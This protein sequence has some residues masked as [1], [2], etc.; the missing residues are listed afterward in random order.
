MRVALVHY[1]L[2]TMRG[3]EKMLEALCRMYPQADIFTHVYDPEA[4][5][6]TIRQH[7]VTTSFIQRLPFAKKAYQRYLPLMPLALEQFDLR[8]Y[9]LVISTESGPAKGVLTSAETTH[10]CYCHTPMRYVWDF[11]QDYLAEAG[12]FTRFAM[13]PLTHYLRMWDALSA[14]RVDHFIANSH[15]VA[16]RIRKHYRR[17]STV[18]YPPVD[19][20]AFTPPL[21]QYAPPQDYYLYLGQLVGYKRADLAVAACTRMNRPLLVMGE[22]PELQRLKAMAGPSVEF[23]GWQPAP[24]IQEKMQQCRALLFPGEEDFGIVPLEAAAA[25]RPVIAYGKG[26]ALETVVHG[27]TGLHF[28]RQTEEALC[29][30][31]EAFEAAEATFTPAVLT[32]HASRFSEDRFQQEITDLVA[33]AMG[34]TGSTGTTGTIDTLR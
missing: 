17:E 12:A 3:G 28:A 7:K 13:R 14:Q 18:I 6:A 15:N 25:G 2:V 34:S 1:W 27:T 19:V 16:R 20:S 22:G 8:G 23:L 5:S 33:S 26:G 32:A 11:Y 24:V 10:I 30:A 21:G 31:M 29:E 4:V 9:D